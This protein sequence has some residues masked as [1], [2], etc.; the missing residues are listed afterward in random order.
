MEIT[1]YRSGN[2]HCPVCGVVIID[3]AKYCNKHSKNGG[4]F[5]NRPAWNK[6]LKG[7]GICKPNSGS[8]KKGNRVG[9][10]ALAKYWAEQG[11]TTNS[12]DLYYL[13]E[14]T[15]TFPNKLIERQYLFDDFNHP[16]DFA[17]P[18]VHLVIEID[19][20][21][22]LRE[23][24]IKRD[25]EVNDYIKNIG[26]KMVRY[27]DKEVMERDFQNKLTLALNDA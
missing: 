25:K 22:H 5:G 21:S 10:E 24:T 9:L 12:E 11:Y 18:S 8:F 20:F 26:W 23:N 3:R 13:I 2:N 1:R 16:F 4:R 15:K 19:G 7:K 17:V 27:T 14:L 6:D